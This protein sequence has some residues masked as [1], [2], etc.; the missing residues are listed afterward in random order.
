[1]AGKRKS[2]SVSFKAK[3]AIAALREQETVAQ[4]ASRFGV[5][6]SQIHQWK[7]LVL[8]G[9]EGLFGAV[10]RPKKGESDDEVVPV[11]YEQIGRLKM[12]LEWLKKKVGTTD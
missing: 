6:A 9:I 3:V 1:M 7:R 5:H 10:G 4:L 12:D 8:D 2:H 11:L